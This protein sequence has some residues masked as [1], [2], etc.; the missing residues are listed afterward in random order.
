MFKVA[1]DIEMAVWLRYLVE[2]PCDCVACAV[3]WNDK[4]QMIVGRKVD[5]SGELAVSSCEGLANT[6]C[7]AQ[8]MPSIHGK[9][10]IK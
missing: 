2:E 9:I 6:I 1:G 7:K 5:D 10:F 8:R 4:L 3:C